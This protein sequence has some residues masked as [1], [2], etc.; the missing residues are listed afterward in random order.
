MTDVQIPLEATMPAYVA[1][2][3]G[4][5]PWPGVVVISDVMGMTTDLRRQADW[6]A[7]VGY[8]AVAPDLFFRGKKVVCLR[9]IFRDAL[10]GR[11]QTFDDI[12]ASRAWLA[13]R[14]DSTGRIGVIGFCMGGG[15]A[16]MLVADHGFAAASSNYGGIPKDFESFLSRACPVVGSYGAKDLSLRG[17]AAELERLLSDAGVLHDVKEYADAG[18]SFLNDHD[19]AEFN[20]LV[21]LLAKVSN[22]AYHEPS[23]LDARRRIVAFF[24]EHLRDGDRG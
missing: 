18:H 24:D 23:A 2:P 8:L 5:G 21:V 20:A 19:P 6:L 4:D 3:E 15:F 9:T 1:V 22:S 16:L 14:D 7:S 17:T 11:G 13:A 12:E 10:R